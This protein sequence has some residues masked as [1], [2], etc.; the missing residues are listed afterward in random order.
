[1]PTAIQF[2]RTTEQNLRP[3][4]T[5]L[6]DGMPMVTLHESDPGL[7]F[8]LQDDSLCK[9]GP[10]VV[11]ITAPNTAPIGQSGNTIGEFWLDTSVTPSSLKVW[12]GTQWV[13]TS[14]STDVV[15]LTDL[16][17]V[18]AASSDF[19]DFQTRIAAL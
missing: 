7:Y 3:N 6:S 15:S 17:S 4:P 10:C 12:D 13:G 11:G 5:N 9:I 1:M 19:T 18:T 16:K 14:G 8:K 2:L